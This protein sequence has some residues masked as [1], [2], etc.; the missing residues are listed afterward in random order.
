LEG[1]RTGHR[2]KNGY[3]KVFLILD[4]Y[5]VLTVWT[6]GTNTIR[7]LFLGLEVERSLKQDR[8]IH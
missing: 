6:S 3:M 4:G 2:E 8:R 7:F 5:R 1:D